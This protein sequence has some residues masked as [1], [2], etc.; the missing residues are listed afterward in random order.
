LSPGRSSVGV[1]AA[2]DSFDDEYVD[3]DERCVAIDVD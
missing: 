2:N 1:R 3:G